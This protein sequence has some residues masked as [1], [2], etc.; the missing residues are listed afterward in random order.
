[1]TLSI[2][3]QLDRLRER[4][5]TMNIKQKMVAEKRRKVARD[6]QDAIDAAELEVAHAKGVSSCYCFI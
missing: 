2:S 1:M 4:E 3:K 5:A 6:E